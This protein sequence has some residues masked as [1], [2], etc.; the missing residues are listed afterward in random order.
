MRNLLVKTHKTIVA[1][2]ILM[3]IAVQPASAAVVLQPIQT[4]S[5]KPNPTIEFTK[6]DPAPNLYRIQILY[7]RKIAVYWFN[8]SQ[9]PRYFEIER[10]KEGETS[11]T[12]IATTGIGATSYT[13][14]YA[15]PNVN[16]FY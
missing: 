16:Y 8:S 4:V 7:N 1:I 12:R 3:V 6:F 11:Y 10:R 13:D 15:L 5:V 9:T 2:I 14:A